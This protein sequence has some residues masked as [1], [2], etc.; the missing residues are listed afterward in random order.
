LQNRRSPTIHRNQ[1]A[2]QPLSEGRSAVEERLAKSN[3]SLTNK[4]EREEVT[5][6]KLLAFQ[7]KVRKQVNLKK[8][9]DDGEGP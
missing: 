1:P 8:Q 2:K 6:S 4:K 9:N 5:M 3:K 7:G